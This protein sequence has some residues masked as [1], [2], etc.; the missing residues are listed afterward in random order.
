MD[1]T[2]DAIMIQFPKKSLV[3]HDVKCLQENKYCNVYLIPFATELEEVVGCVLSGAAGFHT[4]ASLGNHGSLGSV[5]HASPDDH[6]HGCI[7]N[8]QGVCM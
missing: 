7:C 1:I 5:C 4:N 2:S 3:W 8:A 6:G